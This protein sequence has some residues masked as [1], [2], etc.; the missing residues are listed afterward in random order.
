MKGETSFKPGILNV[1]LWMPLLQ[2]FSAFQLRI[3]WHSHMSYQQRAL[4][5][6]SNTNQQ[7]NTLELR[8]MFISLDICKIWWHSAGVWSFLFCYNREL[9]KAEKWEL[10]FSCQLPHWTSVLTRLS[11][12]GG[13]VAVSLQ[14]CILLT[15]HPIIFKRAFQFTY[16]AQFE[17]GG[18]GFTVPK[19][20]YPAPSSGWA[21]RVLT[22]LQPGAAAAQPQQ[23][24]LGTQRGKELH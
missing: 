7:E 11:E 20:S 16:N 13:F 12:K 14:T 22:Q 3:S 5:G 23:Q 18:T 4:L 10:L 21:L 24:S 17:E 1:C 8:T 15:Q 9:S 19:L 6:S 2:F